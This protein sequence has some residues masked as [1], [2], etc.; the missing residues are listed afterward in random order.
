METW[1]IV[2]IIVFALLMW[3]SF[4]VNGLFIVIL[5]FTPAWQMFT[6]WW[7]RKPLIWLHS[8][9]NQVELVTG[10]RPKDN[11]SEVKGLGPFRL[12]RGTGELERKSKVLMYHVLTDNCDTVTMEKAAVINELRQQGYN[13]FGWQDLKYLMDA[14]TNDEWVKAKYKD[15]NATQPT[16]AR[17]FKEFVEKVRASQIP[18][19]NHRSYRFND[20][21][22]L[23]P[24]D[25]NPVGVESAIDI[26]VQL[27]RKKR[28][29][30]LIKWGAM[31]MFALLLLIG[32]AIA[33]TIIRQTTSPEIIVKLGSQVLSNASVISG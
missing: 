25:F 33:Y 8:M 18:L 5:K 19:F 21:Y 26:A 15:L 22:N 12:Q 14:A 13:L 6:A 24:N 4:M 27:D 1:L 31:A 29:D 9:D 30:Q 17:Q 16:K 28:N 11:W 20:L 32:G 7:K 23:Y 10:S 2:L 3:L